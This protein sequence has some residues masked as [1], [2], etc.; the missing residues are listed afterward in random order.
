M[1]VRSNK[2]INVMNRFLSRTLARTAATCAVWLAA[3]GVALASHEADVEITDP[4]HGDELAF[5]SFPATVSVT[6]D[7]DSVRNDL[8]GLKELRAEYRDV[9]D[10]PSSNIEIFKFTDPFADNSCSPL[11]TPVTECT[12]NTTSPPNRKATV[13][14]NWTVPNPG[15]YVVIVTTVHGTQEGSDDIDVDFVLLTSVVFHAPP[16]VANA[17]LNGLNPKV[18]GKAR[19]CV[20]SFVAQAHGQ[21]ETYGPRGGPYD[22]GQIED[23]VDGLLAGACNF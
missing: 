1:L 4:E 12:I 22:Q 10:L 18:K 17:Y 19:G 9:N 3:S 13:A 15:E 14:F 16:A 7:V 20:I 8:D 23:E 2:R 5:A 11:G 21:H 6:F